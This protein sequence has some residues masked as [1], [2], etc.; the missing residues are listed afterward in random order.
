MPPQDGKVFIVTGA[1]SGM[2]LS[3]AGKQFST[4]TEHL[5]EAQVS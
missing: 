1:S 5:A 4:R 2:G 3:C